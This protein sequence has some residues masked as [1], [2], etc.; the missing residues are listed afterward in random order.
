[1]FRMARSFIRKNAI[2]L[3]VVL[4]ASGLVWVSAKQLYAAEALASG[5]GCIDYAC[6]S[7]DMCSWVD[8]GTCSTHVWRCNPKM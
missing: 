1:M 7:D 6:G 5:S 3:T 2:A 4:V 8:C